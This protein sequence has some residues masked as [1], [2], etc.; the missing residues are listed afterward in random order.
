[1]LPVSAL[2][3]AANKLRNLLYNEI[4]DLDDV[5][6]IKIGHPK[7]TFDEIESSNDNDKNHLNL[8]FYNLQYDGYPSDGLSENPFYVR[9]YCLITAVGTKGGTISPGEQDLRLIGEVMRILHEQPVLSVDSDDNIEMAQLQI[10]PHTL[11]LD[12][13]NHIWSTQGETAYRLSVAYELALAPIPLAQ[14]TGP[15][16]LVGDSKV[17]S[18]GSMQR[19]VDKE[20]EGL[21]IFKPVVEFVEIDTAME[22]WAPQICF[23]QRIDAETQELQHVFKV[24]TS[25]SAEL[26]IMIA[27]KENTKLKFFWN[28]WRRKKD[29]SVVTWKEDI[30]DT[31]EPKIKEIKNSPGATE[32]FF[33]NRIDPENIDSRRIVKAKLPVDVA[34]S[35]TKTWQAVLYAIYEWEHEDPLGSGN[36]IKT[37]VRSNSILFVGLGT[38]A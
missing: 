27:G 1:V 34:E 20:K 36:V 6:R 38:S 13:L 29:N 9:L 31:V 24:D 11:N 14:A 8:F 7:N 22:N 18:W 37:P 32:P 26:D 5:K 2:S 28:V 12:N 33:P 3:D 30:A 23:V 17:V 4:D 25:L 19:P 16:A 21:I 35:D 15:G 10:V